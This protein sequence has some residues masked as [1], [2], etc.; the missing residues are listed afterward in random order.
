MLPY[1]IALFS[2]ALTLFLNYIIGKPGSEFSPY[3]IFSF[4]T[5]YLAKKRLHKVGLL[6]TYQNQYRESLH[7]SMTRSERAILEIDYKKML[8]NAADPFFGWER[9]VGMCSICTGFWISLFIGIIF[10]WN[11]PIRQEFLEVAKNVVFCHIIIRILN[12]FL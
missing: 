5:I 1:E 8:Y 12:K 6:F 2:A 3:E 9:A 7:K 10:Y 11:L 4:Y